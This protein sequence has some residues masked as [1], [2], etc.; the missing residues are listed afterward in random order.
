MNENNQQHQFITNQPECSEDQPIALNNENSSNYSHTAEGLSRSSSN[1]CFPHVNR[2]HQYNQQINNIQL[3]QNN[4]QEAN[5]VENLSRSNNRL[6]MNSSTCTRKDN[7]EDNNFPQDLT[8]VKQEDYSLYLPEKK[9]LFI[10][11]F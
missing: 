7:L 2:H 1:Q 5:L 8:Q 11:F 3:A 10:I 4:S 6:V 9:V